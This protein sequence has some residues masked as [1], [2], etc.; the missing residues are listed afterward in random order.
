VNAGASLVLQYL[1]SEKD[2]SAVGFG[3]NRHQ[4]GLALKLQY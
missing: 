2:S 3:Y 4:V 1:Y